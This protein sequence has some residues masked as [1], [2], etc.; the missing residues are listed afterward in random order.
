M[1]LLTVNPG[2]SSLK[3]MLLDGEDRPLADESIDVEG[4][5]DA[6][7]ALAPF[8]ARA[9]RPGAAALRFVHGGRRLREPQL[10]SD[11]TLAELDALGDLAPLHNVVSL[12][13][14]RELRRLAPGL[15]QVL[16]F[17]TAFHAS[18]PEAARTYA[19]P[20]EW[21]ERFDLRR[22]GFHGLSH[23]W[24]ARRAGEL[25]GTPADELRVVTC[26]AGAGVSLA[27]VAHGRS[28][29]TTMGFTPNE[30]PPMARRSGSVDP[31]AILWLA[32]HARLGLAEVREALERRSG[33]LGVSGV[34]TDVREV[35]AAADAGEARAR[36]ALELL[37]H[38]LCGAIAAMA[39]AMG[40]L[41]ALAFT[42][43][44]GENS[45]RVRAM[46][47]ERLGFLGVELDATPNAAGGGDRAIHARGAAVPTL[48]V[49]AREDLVM[50]AEARRVLART[51][52]NP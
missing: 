47:C 11:A 22:F 8:L 7:A 34:S 21:T 35:E 23:A 9:P 41:D 13:C 51:S 5:A 29:D 20:W 46:T 50:A 24:A 31:G 25:I 4:T 40:G 19:V 17:D 42:G 27:A 28:V 48:V 52:E 10:A 6:A 36:L 33:L 32:E 1:N 26:H 30:G 43:G 38:R 37:A 12:A 14:A 18:L 3:L 45:A 49:R 15:P 16:C 39:A 44:I 2:S